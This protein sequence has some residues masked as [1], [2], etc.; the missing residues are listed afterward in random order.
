MSRAFS[1]DLD[2]A[3]ERLQLADDALEQRR[4][5]RAVRPDQRQHVALPD[6]PL[7]MVHGRM[8]VVAEREILKGDGRTS[9]RDHTHASAH[10]IKSHSEISSSAA[11]ASRDQAEIGNSEKERSEA[12]PPRP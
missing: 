12:A 10:T 9:M 11:I 5:A 4:F 1:F 2:A 6:H 8:P 3:V 7:D